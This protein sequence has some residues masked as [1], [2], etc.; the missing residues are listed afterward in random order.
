MVNLG[1]VDIFSNSF[2]SLFERVLKLLQR[3]KD[4]LEFSLKFK[5]DNL[6][7]EKVEE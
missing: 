3:Q 6:I 5:N 7:V 1:S 4:D 2:Q